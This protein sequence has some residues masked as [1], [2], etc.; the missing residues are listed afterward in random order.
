MG[1]PS[2]CAPREAWPSAHLTNLLP[3]PPG[4]PALL[5]WYQ[6]QNLECLPW[7]GVGGPCVGHLA[8]HFSACVGARGVPDGRVGPVQHFPGRIWSQAPC[9]SVLLV[10]K[11]V[12]LLKKRSRLGVGNRGPASG[13]S[14][15]IVDMRV[16]CAP[17]VH[18]QGSGSGSC[19]AVVGGSPHPVAPWLGL[20]DS[21]LSEAPWFEAIIP[22]FTGKE[23]VGEEQASPR[24]HCNCWWL[25]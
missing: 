17:R 14:V 2:P 25:L 6:V 8:T 16:R 19:G 3:W 18:H 11:V 23:E 4:P 7:P 9:F 1:I 10:Q 24:H 13:C 12:A 22:L 15:C 20:W 5:G 21:G